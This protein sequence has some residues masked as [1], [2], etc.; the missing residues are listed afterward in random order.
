VEIIGESL[1]LRGFSADAAT[2]IAK[3][4][5][6]STIAVYESKW[7]KFTVWCGAREID[8]LHPTIPQVASFLLALHAENLKP[9]TIDGYRSAIAT[10]IRAT[11]GPDLG[12]D[13]QLT[14][15]IK[16]LYLQNPV[17]RPQ[18]PAWNL[19]FVLRVLMSAPFEPMDI[20]PLKFVTLK[21]AFLLA[22]ATASRRSELHAFLEEGLGIPPIGGQLLF[23]LI[24]HLSPKLESH[25]GPL[26]SH[27][28]LWLVLGDLSLR[29]IL[30]YVR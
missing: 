10:T 5:K 1:R 19:A 6:S 24:L 30:Y 2:C 7:R 25:Q 16:S 8:P 3:P 22:F 20:V 15:L 4:Q 26:L 21:T 28:Q 9:S 23:I 14:S 27:C 11:G 29:M 18:P 13:P 17:T 12:H